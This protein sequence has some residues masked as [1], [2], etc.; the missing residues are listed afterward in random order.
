VITRIHHA[1]IVVKRLADGY[2]F[3]RDVLGLPLVRE[4]D[5]PEQGVRAA[6]LS[7][8]DT[9]V[10][11]LEPIAPGTGVAR[12][13]E[14]RGEGL[15]H[16]CFETPDV[17]AT[18]ADLAARGVPLIDPTPRQGL[19]G[20]IAFLHPRACDGVLCEIATPPAGD[21]AAHTSPL[22][23]KRLVVGARDVAATSARF[24]DLFRL[25]EVP[26][27]GGPRA[28]LSVGRSTILVV[29]TDEVGGTE[30]MVALSFVSD[31]FEALGRALDRG[32]VRALRGT[33]EVTV[34]PASSHGVHL[35]ISRYE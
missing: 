6:L 21:A 1:G 9:E 11:L 10:E 4:A 13:L 31:A 32:G 27:N 7:A 15:H 30:G 33:G 24:Q 19:A 8:G 2:R 28:M 18:L 35:H 14:K 25:S 34:E 12:F 16:V 26:M 5:V 3:Y 23:F 22:R 17:N 20:T 29:P